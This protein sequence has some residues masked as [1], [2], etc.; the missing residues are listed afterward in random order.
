[1]LSVSLTSSWDE[2][3]GQF[4]LKMDSCSV[5]EIFVGLCKYQ[6]RNVED[7]LFVAAEL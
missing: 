5:L 6:K 7:Q 2:S 4:A 3:E 1:M